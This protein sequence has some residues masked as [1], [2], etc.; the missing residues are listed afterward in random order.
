MSPSHGDVWAALANPTRRRILDVLADDGPFDDRALSS[1]RCSP[2]VMWS[3]STSKVLRDADLVRVEP[4]GRQR[5]NHLNPVPLQEAVGRWFSRYEQNWAAALASACA[6][7]SNPGRRMSRQIFRGRRWMRGP[8]VRDLQQS[9]E[10]AAPIEAVWAEI[11]K[12]R[13]V[14]RALMDTILET[15]FEPGD[16]LYYKSRDGKRTFIV[17]RIVEVRPPELLAH[18][19]V[20]TT[21]DYAPTLVTWRLSPTASGGTRV[22]VEHTGW[23]D[24]VK[25]VDS[26]DSTWAW[27]LRELKNVLENGIGGHLDG[28][29]VRSD[30]GVSVG[31]CRPGPTPIG[32][33]SRTRC[34]PQPPRAPIFPTTLTTPT[35]PTTSTAHRLPTITREQAMDEASTTALNNLATKTGRSVPAGSPSLDR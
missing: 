4:R 10:I 30:A 26:V 27:I 20:L 17:G 35:A 14:Q 19:Q 34:R 15:G 1:M 29:K 21:R 16:P 28:S 23:Q 2:T 32:S 8:S 24:G 5:L 9:I 6:T 22:T 11:T 3:C 33:T 25:G 13:G 18:T 31:Q 12:L 7:P